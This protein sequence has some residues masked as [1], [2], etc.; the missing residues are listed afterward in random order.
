M[1]NYES[2]NSAVIGY[3]TAGA[4]KGSTI[5]LSVDDEAVAEV[6]SRF[7]D[8]P[9]A[10]DPV[11]DLVSAVRA[12]TV[13]DDRFPPRVGLD[14]LRGFAGPQPRGAAFLAV[15]V[16]AAYRMHEEEGIDESNYFLR[17]RELL[18]LPSER[19]RPDGMVAGSEEPLWLAWNDHITRSGFQA[20]AERGS[21]PQTY[22][23]Y[24]FSQAILRESDKD[25]LCRRFREAGLSGQL[26][27][28]QLGFWLSRQQINRR[29][30]HEGLTH[31]EP[32]RVWEFYRAAHRLYETGLWR[33]AGPQASRGTDGGATR[34]IE[35]GL[36]RSETLAGAVD[37]LLFPRQPGRSKVAAL[38]ASAG[39]NAPGFPLRPLRPG[40]FQPLWRQSPFGQQAIEFDVEGDVAIKAMLFPRRD[41]WIMTVDP[42]NPMGAWAT[43]KP[44]IELGER[45]LVLVGSG[46]FDE[47]MAR[48]RDAKLIDWEE[49][50]AVDG[51]VEYTKCMVLSYDWGGYI[52]RPECRSLAD[53]LAPRA[54]AGVSLCGG[55]RDPN[56]NAWLRG[57]GPRLRVYGFERHFSVTIVGAGGQV[58]CADVE[59]QQD[60]DLAQDLDAGS[61]TVE[62][63]CAGRKLGSRIFRIVEWD[64]IQMHPAPPELVNSAITSTAGLSLCGPIITPVASSSREAP[65]G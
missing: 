13:Q 16:L 24:V 26:D 20:S 38:V 35:C 33:D 3:V 2:W 53:A 49:R 43:W 6:A 30:L 47:E 17:L 36:Y 11:V 41:F 21:G 46:A 42:E 54:M 50:R 4:A 5:F 12:R 7:L 62:V 25:H 28:D 48:F 27:C 40:F 59:R 10:G 65:H 61:Y 29:H 56:Q 39:P 14:A 18:R 60:V 52:P 31:R 51:W 9:V 45:V 64:A 8:Q 15:M 57:H 32:A 37:Y 34:R 22:L 55:L 23:R 63:S 19:C 44:Y 58:T 1:P